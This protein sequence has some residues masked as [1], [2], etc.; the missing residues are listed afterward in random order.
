MVAE[1]S[2]EQEIY[3]GQFGEF[4][5]T[6]AD[7]RGV[8]VY[9]ASLAVA[10]GSFAIA[11]AAIWGAGDRPETLAWL[12]P[13]FGLFSASLGAALAT[14]HIYLRPLHRLLQIFWGI[15]TLSAAIFAWQ[16][17][18]PLWLYLSQHSEAIFGVGFT[19]AALTGIYFK[20]AFCFDRLET[21]VLTPLVPMLLLGH[22]LGIYPA[23]AERVML[24]LWAAL[25]AIFALRKT[26]QAI[27]PDIGDKSVFAYLERQ[28]A[29]SN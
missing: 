8:I 28:R 20:E 10:A 25:F 18:E 11:T 19:F 13:L 23:I 16:S 21:K 7:R 6:D 2:R 4:E 17:P 29:Q 26:L 27:P 12:T 3:R 24:V 9:R 1:A 5:I 22:W 15:G 14:I